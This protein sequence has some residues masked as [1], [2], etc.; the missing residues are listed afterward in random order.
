MICESVGART[1]EVALLDAKVAIRKRG[2]GPRERMLQL[3]ALVEAEELH[4][5]QL[6]R[7][8]GTQTTAA[9]RAARGG[10]GGAAAAAAAAS[11]AR[12]P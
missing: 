3:Q 10:A 6:A 7:L 9:A 11:T 2:A 12:R 8:A 1:P 5:E 4:A